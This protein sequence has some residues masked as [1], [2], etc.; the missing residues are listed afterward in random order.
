MKINYIRAF[1]DNYIWTIENDEGLILV[2]PGEADPALTYIEDKDPKAIL[3]THKHQDHVGGVGEI[4]E[5]YSDIKIIGPIETED[6]NDKTVK[7]GDTFSLLGLDFSVIKTDGHTDEH[8]SYLVDGRLFCGD[9]LFSS[10]C[11]RCFT[12]KYD[13]S[14]ES[15]K[16][17]RALPEETLV[18]PAHEYTVKHIKSSMEVMDSDFLRKA[19]AEAE[20]SLAKGEP[21]LPTSIKNEYM[22]N[23]Y[24]AIDDLDEFKRVL[25]IKSGL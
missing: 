12:K 25:E 23:P 13:R 21:T 10:G 9:A 7:E 8:I 3:L 15:I 18:Y 16:K 6:L 2:D 19:L 22:I 11:G 4:K 20:E 5:A 24:F 14:F 1:E 17:I